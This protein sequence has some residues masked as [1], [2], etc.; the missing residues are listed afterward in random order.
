VGYQI[1]LG[2][3]RAGL[4]LCRFRDRYGCSPNHKLAGCQP[5]RTPLSYTTQW[6]EHCTSEALLAAWID[7][8]TPQAT[9]AYGA[10]PS[11]TQRA[12]LRRAKP[13]RQCLSEKPLRPR[14]GQDHQRAL[15]RPPKVIHRHGPWKKPWAV[16]STV[17]EGSGLDHHRLFD[18]RSLYGRIPPA[19]AEKITTGRSHSGFRINLFDTTDIY[20]QSANEELVGPGNSGPM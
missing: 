20:N 2:L 8:P 10:R 3:D 16:E 6:S 19:K 14:T 15:T 1:D 18:Y 13:S 11:A 17:L 7:E 5:Q 12:W 4:R 9:K